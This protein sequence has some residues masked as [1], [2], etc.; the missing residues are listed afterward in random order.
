MAK[1]NSSGWHFQSTRHS[2]ARRT[3]H[4]GGTY[5]SFEHHD[6]K[7]K[8][9]II[10][11][12]PARGASIE[13][14]NILIKNAVNKYHLNEYEAEMLDKLMKT[15]FKGE[16]SQSYINEWAGR[17]KT[18][19]PENY[20]DIQ[21]TKAINKIRTER[22]KKH[23]GQAKETW[24]KKWEHVNNWVGSYWINPRTNATIR[25]TSRQDRDGKNAF[26]YTATQKEIEVGAYGAKWKEKVIAKGR[27]ESLVIKKTL[28]YMKDNRGK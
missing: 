9:Q 8:P 5:S 2:N 25:I 23:F 18:G 27:N 1:Y 10:Y 26:V 13:E 28:D 7:S 22:A 14:Q 4:A 16:E 19:H 24:E 21:T 11:T 6:G 3:G 12:H 20:A 15:R 17:I